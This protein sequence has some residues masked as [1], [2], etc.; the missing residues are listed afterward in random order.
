MKVTIFSYDLSHNCLVR[1][2]VLAQILDENHEVEIVGPKSEPSVW[3]PLRDKY[4]YK[5][6]NTTSYIWDYSQH[7]SDLR[8]KISGDVVF[9]RKPR[10]TSFGLCLLHR[11][12][13]DTP[14][15]VDIEDWE[16]GLHLSYQSKLRAG[17]T[18]LPKIVDL[19]SIY[20]TLLM[21]RLVNRADGVTVSNTFLQKKF[22]GIL[23]PHLRDITEFDPDR[24]DAESLRDEHGFASDST[25]IMFTG[26]PRPHKGVLEL[27]KAAQGLDRDD[28][29]VAIVGAGDT[30]YVD[31]IERIAG[32]SV[33]LIPPQPF[34]EVPK[35][36]SMADIVVAPKKQTEGLYGQ[37]PAKVFDA[38][39]MGKPIIAT[40]IS[41]LPEIIEGCGILIDEP[42]PTSLRDAI[43][44]LVDN[45]DTRNEYA[46]KARQR[47]VREFSVKSAVPALDDLMMDIM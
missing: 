34:N 10:A 29:T 24:F 40:S 42:T 36:V 15:I 44:T 3:K 13:T 25:V 18:G 39:A 7:V 45:P 26:T 38:M 17:L 12:V 33:R 2:H 21:E 6:I 43:A 47:A 27:V 9:V 31:E 22:G 8:S 41:D 35:W 19:N 46:R 14:V 32:D 5:G 11:A 28:V 20:P 1:T 37:I 16:V 4:E 30:A 23:I